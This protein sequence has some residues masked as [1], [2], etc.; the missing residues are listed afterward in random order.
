MTGC[1]A[2]QNSSSVHPK[3]EGPSLP[4]QDVRCP[5]TPAVCIRKTGGP[6]CLDRVRGPP[7]SSLPGQG[8][9]RPRTPAVCIRKAASRPH[10]WTGSREIWGK[11]VRG[12]L[13][14]K[15]GT[16]PGAQK[17]AGPRP[18]G[19]QACSR[20]S[21]DR[22]SGAIPAGSGEGVQAR[23]R[24][25]GR[26]GRGAAPERAEAR[27]QGAPGPGWLTAPPFPRTRPP[28]CPPPPAW[29]GLCPACAPL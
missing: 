28:L 5:Q 20:P 9:R 24:K 14:P 22:V 3:D 15:A 10:P 8:V 18:S 6:H 26:S 19:R 7:N 2:P 23:T 11:T 17:G 12:L 29:A 1:K 25:A 13:G 27:G 4:G 16:D 21:T